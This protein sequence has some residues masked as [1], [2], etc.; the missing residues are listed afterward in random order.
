MTSKSSIPAPHSHLPKRGGTY[1]L[2][3]L[4]GHYGLVSLSVRGRD[5]AWT[6]A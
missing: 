2:S 6:K 3:H 5:V 4:Y 1:P